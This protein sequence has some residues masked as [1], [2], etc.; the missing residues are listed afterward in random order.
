MTKRSL[1]FAA[2]LL[3]TTPLFA[4]F[5]GKP[6]RIVVPFPA[7]SATDTITRIIGQ[8]VST[9]VGQPVIVDNKVGADGAIAGAEV[10]KAANRMIEG[11]MASWKHKHIFREV[12]KICDRVA[13]IHRGKVLDAGTLDELRDRHKERDLEEL[14]FDLIDGSGAT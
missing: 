14:F 2:A 11:P 3:F 6:I 10:V 13:I 7:G 12:E 5:P 8:S 4:Q 1:A 9:A